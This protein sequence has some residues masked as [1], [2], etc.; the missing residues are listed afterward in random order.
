MAY[1]RVSHSWSRERVLADIGAAP[2]GSVTSYASDSGGAAPMEVNAVQ[3]G[4]GKWKGKQND[5][6]KGKST[7]G[8]DK[9]K[10]KSKSYDK[11]KGKSSKR[12]SLLQMSQ[13][14][15]SLW[16]TS[17]VQVGVLFRQIQDHVW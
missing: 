15:L 9:G 5:K 3:K 12:S 13:H 6:G 8:Y 4:K 10:G 14:H 7:H 2:L 11:G 1:E 17:Y 16:V